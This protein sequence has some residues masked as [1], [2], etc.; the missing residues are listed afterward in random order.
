MMTKAQSTVKKFYFLDYYY[1]LL[2][3]VEKFSSEEAIFNHF[4][5]L[6]QKHRLGESKYKRI[7]ADSEE[8]SRPQLNR[9]YYTFQQVLDEAEQHHLVSRK[10]N[11]VFIKQLG[12]KLLSIYKS[13]G[14]NQFNEALLTLLEKR[15]G[16]FRELLETLYNGNKKKSGLLVLPF[17]SP[18]L[19]GFDKAKM[20]TT[21]NLIDYSFALVK[22][23][24]SD[25]ETHVGTQLNL[26]PHNNTIIERLIKSHLL[27]LDT[28][29]PFQADKYNIIIKR[30]RDYWIGHFLNSLYNYDFSMSTFDI[31]AYR[32][33]QIG[34]IHATEFYPG[35][36]GRVVY[37]LAVVSQSVNS[38]D[39]RSLYTYSDGFQLFMHEPLEQNNQ[40]KFIDYLVKGYFELKKSVRTYFISLP[41]LRELVCYNMKISE[42][43]FEKYLNSMYKIILEGSLSI[44]ISLEADKLP[45]ETKAMYLTKEPVLVGSEFRNIIAIDVTRR[46]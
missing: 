46:E 25:I 2:R 33:K 30:L 12:I 26:K 21:Q 1:V 14:Q 42:R 43:I 13:K 16:A 36:H 20:T 32:A 6:K 19:L 22:R 24:E 45:E 11:K 38:S 28:S 39:F 34:I 9:Y 35:F 7:T 15:Y 8:L 5:V 17:Y 31:W 40:N 41:R 3:S 10:A 23:L 37:P 44:R 27:N 4:K 18:R 29:I